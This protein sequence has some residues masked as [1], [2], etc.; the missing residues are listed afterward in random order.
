MAVV[1]LKG[2]KVDKM[3]FVALLDNGT[4]VKLAH[5]YQYNVQ[6][7]KNNMCKGEFDIEVFDSNNPDKFKVHV[8]MSGIFSFKEGEKKEQIHTNTFKTLF[9][10]L[11]AFVTTLTA[12]CGIPPIMIP[13]IDIDNQE[14]Y[15]IDNNPQ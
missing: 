4:Q 10:Y 12:N 9:P 14:I 5:K 3:D 15:R 1:S 8:V 11:K 13:D 7:G 6:Y 2:Y